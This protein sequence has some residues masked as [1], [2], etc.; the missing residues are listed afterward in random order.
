MDLNILL[1][2]WVSRWTPKFHRATKILAG[3][4]FGKA[5]QRS[6]M[7]AGV[8]KCSFLF[9]LY[10]LVKSMYRIGASTSCGEERKPARIFLATGRSECK[11]FLTQE[12]TLTGLENIKPPVRLQLS[13]Y[14]SAYLN[15]D[16]T[17]AAKGKKRTTA[18]INGGMDIKYG[19]NQAFTLDM[20]LIPDFG[21]VQSD[22]RVLNLS[23]FE[24]RFNENRSFL[25]KVLNCLIR[26][27]YFTAA[28]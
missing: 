19:I 26:E 8:L 18:T 28:E 21:Q 7:M 13:P 12:G 1:H 25:Q 16:G 24:Q 23:P 15:N 9:Q 10:V 5:H 6:T 3:M 14:M 11:W 20:T 27:I 22:N 2:P 4:P 17:D